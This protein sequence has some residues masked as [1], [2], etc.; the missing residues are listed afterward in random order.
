MCVENDLSSRAGSSGRRICV[1]KAVRKA[2]GK[3]ILGHQQKSVSSAYSV[4]WLR[5]ESAWSLLKRQLGERN[6]S[7]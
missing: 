2:R 3:L 4:K 6:Q 1:S 7:E 5:L